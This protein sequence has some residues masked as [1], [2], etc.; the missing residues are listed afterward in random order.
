MQVE[1][2]VDMKLF[3]QWQHKQRQTGSL[4]DCIQYLIDASL[5]RT[6]DDEPKVIA[7]LSLVVVIDLSQTADPV[8]H[9]LQLFR[10]HGQGSE[11]AASNGP[12]AE[13]RPDTADIALFAEP[14][15]MRNDGFLREADLLAYFQKRSAA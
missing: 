15:N 13:H 5:V 3:K 8:R 4:P 14:C 10:G 7:V 9:G 6:R 12:R 11:C 2:E 1:P